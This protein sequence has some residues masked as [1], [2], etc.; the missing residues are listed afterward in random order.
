LVLLSQVSQRRGDYEKF[1]IF[2]L[3]LLN[4][5]PPATV[6]P[7][8]SKRTVVKSTFARSVNPTRVKVV[9]VLVRV[10]NWMTDP[11][12]AKL[13]WTIIC[14]VPEPSRNAASKLDREN[15]VPPTAL[16]SIPMRVGGAF[17][18]Q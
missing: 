11:P 17:A 12:P 10:S 18:D 16:K 3:T 5:P 15:V 8:F 4:I 1:A 2:E 6:L 14:C 9:Q 13:P 7:L